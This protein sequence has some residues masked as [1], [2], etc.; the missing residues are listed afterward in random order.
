MQAKLGKEKAGAMKKDLKEQKIRRTEDIINL[1]RPVE[2][3]QRAV[4]EDQKRMQQLMIH[5]NRLHLGADKKQVSHCI[6]CHEDN[7]LGH[8]SEIILMFC[9]IK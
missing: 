6:P 7:H 3:V 8:P 2:E 9:K 1:R 5:V 4:E